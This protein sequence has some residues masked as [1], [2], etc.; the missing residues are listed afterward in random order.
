[1]ASRVMVSLVFDFLF[2]SPNWRFWRVRLSAKETLPIFPLCGAMISKKNVNWK[3]QHG[4]RLFVLSVGYL[5]TPSVH[6]LGDG[7]SSRRDRCYGP[8]LYGEK[9]SRMPKTALDPLRQLYRAVL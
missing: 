8:H 4:G 9:S 6:A 1:M 3:S 7:Q 2:I 5:V